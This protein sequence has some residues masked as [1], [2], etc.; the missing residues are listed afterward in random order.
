M[1]D[2]WLYN[3]SLKQGNVLPISCIP[4]PFIPDNK[5]SWRVAHIPFLCWVATYPFY[6]FHEEENP[7]GKDVALAHDFGTSDYRLLQQ[8]L[9]SSYSNNFVF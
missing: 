3:F 5:N 9:I 6:L 8:M 4:H 7:I 2:S 1:F